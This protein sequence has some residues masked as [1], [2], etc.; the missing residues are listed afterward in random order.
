MGR[1]A[2]TLVEL[3]VVI[4]IIALLIS[5]VLPSLA[6]AR[7]ASRQVV[8]MSNVSQFAIAFSLYQ[9]DH[10]GT[11]MT[12]PDPQFISTVRWGGKSGTSANYS[13]AMGWGV[14]QR[15]MNPYVG[16][17]VQGGSPG[18]ET[19]AFRCPGDK[20][21][22]GQAER[23]YDLV[24]TSYMYNRVSPLGPTTLH[25][26]NPR[27][28]R[29]L[30]LS[31][32]RQPGRVIQVADHPAFNFSQSGDRRQRWHDPKRPTANI[33]FVDGHVRHCLIENT[34]TGDTREYQWLP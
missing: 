23:V 12:H 33:G 30:R 26:L 18:M 10:R 28:G 4:A 14:G 25:Q 21:Q 2:F 3:L 32:V 9:E 1:R 5:L 20:G 27:M 29:G 8:C 16:I 11:M 19:P 6:G 17:Q 22:P 13:E 24:G 15:V 31:S 34:P 7:E